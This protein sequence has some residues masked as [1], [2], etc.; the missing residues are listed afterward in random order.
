MLLRGGS[1]CTGNWPCC[2]SRR[3]RRYSASRRAAHP[4]REAG[5]SWSAR[6]PGTGCAA[7]VLAPFKAVEGAAEDAGV[8]V[9]RCAGADGEMVAAD[10]AVR[11]QVV[12]IV[13]RVVRLRAD[14]HRRE[15]DDAAMNHGVAVIPIGGAQ[16][17]RTRPI[18]QR[19]EPKM[20]LLTLKAAPIDTAASTRSTG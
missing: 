1:C 15:F 11:A 9:G 17:E 3:S 18:S 13:K 20:P 19:P 4:E 2:P 8:G 10:A 5:K 7:I 16:N 6:R 12:R 14:R